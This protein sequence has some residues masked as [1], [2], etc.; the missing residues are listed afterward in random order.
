MDMDT[1]ANAIALPGYP[2]NAFKTECNQ[3][4]SE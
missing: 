4:T 2:L 3:L 1:E